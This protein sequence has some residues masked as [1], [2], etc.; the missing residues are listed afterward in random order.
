M[1]T[2]CDRAF[3]PYGR[4]VPDVPVDSL[5]AVVQGFALPEQGMVYSPREDDLHARLE[6][7]PWGTALFADMPYQLGY[8]AGSNGSAEALV[9]HGGSAF[10]CGLTG[11][12]LVV[13]HRWEHA[14]ARF[15]VP[16]QVLIEIYGD[17]LRSAPLGA[18]FRVLV[19]LPYA[20]NTD[21]QG[22]E[23]VTARNTWRE[24]SI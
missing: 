20:T 4:A 6:F 11:F 13:S 9:R 22:P 2:A 12:D 3:L 8:C 21:W 19:L 7:A 14:P 24:R 16:A 18:D 15:H 23:G 5:L 17:T 10:V 1:K